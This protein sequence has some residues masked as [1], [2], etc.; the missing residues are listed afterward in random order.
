MSKKSEVISAD[1]VVFISTAL[2]SVAFVVS[3]FYIFNRDKNVYKLQSKKQ[4]A[5]MASIANLQKEENKNPL[6]DD[7]YKDTDNDGLANW[8]EILWGTDPNNPDSDGDGVNDG[9]E[10]KKENGTHL[11]KLALKIEEDTSQTDSNITKTEI[12]SKKIFDSFMETLQN[13]GAFSTE[14]SKEIAS[15]ALSVAMRTQTGNENDYVLNENQ[16]VPATFA[17]RIIYIK[18][19]LNELKKM[20]SGDVENE[21]MLLFELAQGD[22][23][24][25]VKKISKTAQFYNEHTHI[26][27]NIKVP[28]DVAGI[29][30]EMIRSLL[31]YTKVLSDLGELFNDPLSSA[32][33]INS[34]ESSKSKLSVSFL[35]LRSYID[36]TISG[37]NK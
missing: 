11:K 34:F 35:K 19:V 23:K 28:S 8:E 25:A 27:M 21:I 3:V 12:V 16:L 6:A 1:K 13:G 22:K 24:D 14:K 2:I 37:K 5:N 7:E 10:A 18:T 30:V 26:L 29:H 33:A 15:G 17:N 32:D 9:D 31:K 4:S 36:K 20:S